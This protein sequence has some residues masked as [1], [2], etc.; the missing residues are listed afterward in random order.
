[1]GLGTFVTRDRCEEPYEA[2][3]KQIREAVPGRV[4]RQQSGNGFTYYVKTTGHGNSFATVQPNIWIYT[5]PTV[6]KGINFSLTP[7]H[8]RTTDYFEPVPDNEQ[9]NS[10]FGY[11]HETSEFECC[12]LPEPVLEAVAESYTKVENSV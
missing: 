4:A 7:F 9:F 6:R 5:D 3:D 2:I 12:D 11:R 1:M 10:S 8:I